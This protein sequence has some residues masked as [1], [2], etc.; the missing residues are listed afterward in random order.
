MTPTYIDEVQQ[1]A[2]AFNYE[3]CSCCLRDLDE[4]IIGPDML[5]HAHAFCIHEEAA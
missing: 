4:H 2:D 1:L 5:G 3:L